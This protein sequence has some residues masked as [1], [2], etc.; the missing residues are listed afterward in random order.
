MKEALDLSSER[1]LNECLIFV[2]YSVCNLPHLPFV[3][4]RILRWLLDFLEN[5]LTPAMYTQLLGSRRSKSVAAPLLTDSMKAG[6][7]HKIYLQAYSRKA[8]V[9]ALEEERRFKGR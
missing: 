1:I 2:G 6:L 3:M 4:H 5:L 7:Q 8:S 9:E